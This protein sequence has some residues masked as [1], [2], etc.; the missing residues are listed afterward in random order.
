MGR[1]KSYIKN[2]QQFVEAIRLLK[3]EPGH[4]LVSSDTDSRYTNVS[5]E[6]SL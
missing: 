3:L 6:E 4:L 5:V 2:S 1:S